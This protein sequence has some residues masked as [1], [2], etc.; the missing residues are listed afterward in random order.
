M[1]SKK[2]R[3]N[4]WLAGRTWVG[5]EEFATLRRELSISESY[6]RHLLRAAPGVALHPLVEGVRQE[7]LAEL[8]RT[9]LNMRNEPEYRALVRQA[10]DHARLSARSPRADRAAKREMHS[11]LTLWLESPELFPAWLTLRKRALDREKIA[12]GISFS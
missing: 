6:L 7:S 5:P 4:E 9:L 2:T 11:W 3:L 12:S 10:R 8:E 1:P